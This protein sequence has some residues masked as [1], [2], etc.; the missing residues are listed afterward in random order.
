MATDTELVR[1]LAE[2]DDEALRDLLRRYERPLAHFI[3]RHTGGEDVEDLY[4]ETWLRVVREAN[5]FDPGRRFST[6]LFQIA[7]NLCRDRHRRR[8]H[9]EGA[10]AADAVPDTA[11]GYAAVEARLDLGRLLG[12]LSEAQRE[13]LIL[14][15][16]HDLSEADVADIVGCRK[17]TVKSR[18]HHAL[19]RLAELTR[20]ISK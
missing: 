12:E 4:Q 5:R 17:G 10:G 8:A 2:G 15:Y 7:V 6:W 3:S 18:L 9:R 1:R 14:R 19:A 16:Y 11:D 13:V 20:G